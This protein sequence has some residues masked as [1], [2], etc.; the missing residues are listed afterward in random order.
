MKHSTDRIL[1][2]HVG[3]LPRPDDML[4]A[5]RAKM[6]GRPVDEQAR[7]ARLPSAVGE[8]V[9]KQVDPGLHV[10]ND[11]EVGRPSF[12]T[13]VDERLTGFEQR[14]VTEAE[15]VR[16]GSYLAGSREVQAFPEFYQ[17]DVDA[18]TRPAGQRPRQTVCTGPI[19]YKGH[20]Q[21][22][23]DFT[24]LRAALNGA[25]AE[26]VFVPAVSPDQI[27]YRRPN[28]YY[29]TAEE[30][31]VAIADALHEEYRAVV[32]AGFLLQVDDPQLVTHYMRNPGLSV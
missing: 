9:R 23:R 2:T 31:E 10:I 24:N 19:A 3:S 7:E 29:R 25:Q 13:Y 20:A 16:S 5:L 1:T 27:G 22:Q 32:N 26:E 30:Y 21:L 15:A 14:E 12:I 18:M 6:V 17:P 8:V 28:E 4:E 11:G